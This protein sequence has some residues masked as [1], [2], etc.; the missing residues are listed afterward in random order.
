MLISFDR[1]VPKDE[2]NPGNS[3]VQARFHDPDSASAL[4]FQEA[5]S[6]PRSPRPRFCEICEKKRKKKFHAEGN[7][8][9][10]KTNP[11]QNSPSEIP[12]P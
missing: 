7:V 9:K 5:R 3:K 10:D 4:T 1:N 12:N 2:T 6:A 8:P 11:V